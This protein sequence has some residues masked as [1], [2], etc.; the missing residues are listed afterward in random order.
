[1]WMI[2]FLTISVPFHSVFNHDIGGV[3]IRPLASI[4]G[5]SKAVLVDCAAAAP[6]PLGPA[7]H[8]PVNQGLATPES[9]NRT[10]RQVR[11]RRG[12]PTI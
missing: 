11:E 6:A 10:R 3:V 7:S 2:T 12:D 5:L 8:R 4:D 9:N 1:M